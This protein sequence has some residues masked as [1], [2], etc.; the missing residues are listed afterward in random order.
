MQRSGGAG[1][2]AEG[3]AGVA[4]ER[5]G[6]REQAFVALRSMTAEVVEKK[7]AQGAVLTEEDRAFLRSVIAQFD[8]FAAIKGE[9][10]DS[11]GVRAEGRFR[12]GTLR[13][14]LG[15]RK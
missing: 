9:D 10:A 5:G 15:D 12:I 3:E 8:A 4:A 1:D 14:R 2:G 6:A 13:Q 7:F 11:R